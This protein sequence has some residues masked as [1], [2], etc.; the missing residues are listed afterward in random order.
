MRPFAEGFG[1]D[2]QPPRQQDEVE[3]AA[4]H[5]NP[6]DQ[7]GIVHGGP[8]GGPPIR[9]VNPIRITTSGGHLSFDQPVAINLHVPRGQDPRGFQGVVIA[10]DNYSLFDFFE[11]AV[12]SKCYSRE[13]VDIERCRDAIGGFSTLHLS[14]FGLVS[15]PRPDVV[16]APRTFSAQPGY[17]ALWAGQSAYASVSPG[18]FIDL[19]AWFVNTGDTPWL[20]GVLGAQANL[21]ANAPQDNTRD[22][23]A[24]SLLDPYVNGNRYAVQTEARVDPG[25]VGTFGFRWLAP[26]EPGVYRIYVRPVIDGTIWLEDEGVFLQVTVAR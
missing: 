1:R 14:T 22:F 4:A 25:Q 3:Q 17:H 12:R 7:R 6:I 5:P 26:L 8:G 2:E 13:S 10:D 11:A 18:Q 16:A 15:I 9:V 20:R 19:A 21:G 24:G 23:E